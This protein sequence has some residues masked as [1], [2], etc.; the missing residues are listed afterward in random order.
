[1]SLFLNTYTIL[2]SIL[3]SRLTPYPEEIIEFNRV[4]F[5]AT[6]QLLIINSAFVKYLRKKGNAMKQDTSY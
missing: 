3:L 1:M 6:D 2:P 5:D 4:D